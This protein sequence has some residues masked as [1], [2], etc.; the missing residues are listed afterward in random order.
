PFVMCEACL[1]E[2]RSPADRRFHAE[3][4]ACH[5]CGPHLSLLRLDGEAVSFDQHSLLDDVDAAR[6]LIERGDIIA[7]KG[8]GGYQLACDATNAEAVMRLRKRKRRDAKPFAL[9]ARD[10]DVVRRYCRTSPEEEREL[11]G[12]AAPIVLL[13]AHG[14]ER[15]PEAIA[16]GLDTL[17]FMLP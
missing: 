10:L 3:P 2:Y 13:P 9:M 7:I 1:A 11:T 17:G 16:P 15:L 4:I 8:L 14:L 12:A 6:Q 5:D